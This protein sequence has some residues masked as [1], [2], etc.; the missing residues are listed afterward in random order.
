MNTFAREHLPKVTIAEIGLLDSKP[1]PAFD[2]VTAMLTRTLS[3]P[4]SLLSVIDDARERQFFKSQRGLKEP[5]ASRGETPLTHSFCQY[6]VATGS[7][8]IIPDAR[9]DELVACNAAIED[10]GVIAYLGAP[11]DAANGKAVAALCAISDAPR[12]WTTEEVELITVLAA[13]LNDT[14]ARMSAGAAG[15][16]LLERFADAA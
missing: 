7:A 1:E 14:I 8:L 10:L 2:Q 16:L 15:D 11:V 3:V 4:V 12:Q 6:V 9:E 5:W 13:L